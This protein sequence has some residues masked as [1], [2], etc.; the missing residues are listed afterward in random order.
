[1][2]TNERWSGNMSMSDDA[3]FCYDYNRVATKGQTREA[4]E[5]MQI[6]LKITEEA[7]YQ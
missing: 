6:Q 2:S 4:I 1:M 5:S 3:C 7:R